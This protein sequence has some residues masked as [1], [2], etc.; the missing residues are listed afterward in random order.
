LKDRLEI[1]MAYALFKVNGKHVALLELT[2]PL[3]I[4][5]AADCHVSVLDG[6]LSRHHLRLE[7]V[8]RDWFAVDLNSSNG[9][10]VEG[11]WIAR[12]R[13]ED[14]DLIEAAPLS[15]VFHD[16]R[17]PTVQ[18]SDFSGQVVINPDK[19]AADTPVQ[20]RREPAIEQSPEAIAT[21]ARRSIE[22]VVGQR[23]QQWVELA[24]N[25]GKPQVAASPSFNDRLAQLP[26]PLAFSFILMTGCTLFWAAFELTNWIAN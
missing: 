25:Q 16:V 1:E 2:R 8:D 26:R 7:S 14:G 18:A 13:L 23:Q 9:T 12:E 15:I 24:R 3:V 19:L 22:T 11:N 10:I 21:Q 20:T 17:P 6:Q 4:G 5:R